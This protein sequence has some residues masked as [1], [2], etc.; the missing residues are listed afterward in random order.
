MN[1]TL[2]VEN[3]TVALGT[4][5]LFLGTDGKVVL[6]KDGTLDLSSATMTDWSILN[7][8]TGAGASTGDVGTVWLRPSKSDA[9]FMVGQADGVDLQAHYKVNGDLRLNAWTSAGTSKQWLVSGGLEVSGMLQLTTKMELVIK[10]GATVSASSLM[11][12][13]TDKGNPGTLIMEGGTLQTGVITLNDNTANVLNIKGGTVEFADNLADGNVFVNNA[14]DGS[15]SIANAWLT[16]STW[17]LNHD[18][19]LGGGIKLAATESGTVGAD[20]ITITLGGTLLNTGAADT[21]SLAGTWKADSLAGL[22]KSGD[23]TYSEGANGYESALYYILQQENATGGA[24]TLTDTR[25]KLTVGEAAYEMKKGED[26]SIYIATDG[27]GGDYWVN[28]GEVHYAA[29]SKIASDVTTGIVLNGGT[30]LLEQGLSDGTSMHAVKDSGVVIGSGVT[31]ASSSLTPADGVGVTLDGSGTYTLGKSVDLKGTLADTWK[32]KVVIGD[33]SGVTSWESSLDLSQYGKAGSVIELNQTKGALKKDMVVGAGLNLVG[34]DRN[35]AFVMNNGEKLAKYQF[36]GA[37]KAGGPN[38]NFLVNVKETQSFEFTGDVSEWKG[39]FLATQD[40]AGGKGVKNITNVTFKAA[41]GTAS[42]DIGVD[43]RAA[44][45]AEVNMSIGNAEKDV[46]VTGKVSRNSL[47]NQAGGSMNVTV[48]TNGHTTTF[49]Q[50]LEVDSLT[51]KQGTA[52]VRVGEEA[53]EGSFGGVSIKAKGNGDDAV[54][55]N[56]SVGATGLSRVAEEAT[57]SMENAYVLFSKSGEGAALSNISLSLSLVEVA[58]G[59]Q[60]KIENVSL[61]AGSS[62]KGSGYTLM[63]GDNRLTVAGTPTLVE[64]AENSYTLSTGQLAGVQLAAGASLSLDFANL[65]PLDSTMAIELTDFSWASLASG[66]MASDNA[67]LQ[68]AFQ[69]NNILVQSATVTDSG[70]V[71]S[72]QVTPEPTTTTLSLLGLAML[73]ARRRR[74]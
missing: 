18:M 66:S 4:H 65:P 16:G 10:D 51:V 22:A 45:G 59:G 32:G 34:S 49:A 35:A 15:V 27:T 50:S 30:L 31:L 33:S 58:T 43:V 73:M 2:A 21:I 20:G 39:A 40:S 14:N 17:K 29:G 61:D 26:G 71:L 47:W 64:G 62:I 48:D 44:Y 72:V 5:K 8:V 7:K 38:A 56:V 3:G 52:A 19:V 24:G 1:G 74:K 42:A 25:L 41:P 9:H 28:E 6:S 68:S 70:L 36:N 63:S 23:I 12:G 69:G 57:A 55:K 46:L 13:H 67:L 60:T 53:Q 54:L 11:L 37:V